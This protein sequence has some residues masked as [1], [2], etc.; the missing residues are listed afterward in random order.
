[1][2]TYSG[3][4]AWRISWTEE[5]G[6]LQSMGSQESD[7]TEQP[8]FHSHFQVFPSSASGKEPACQCRKCERCRF[9]TWVRKIP[10]DEGMATHSS[11]LA[12]RIPWT[13]EPGGL[14]S[15]RLQSVKHD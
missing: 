14:Q 4:L 6:G 15:V 10:P 7:M 13:E 2:A 5:P 12:W 8:T 3:I 11:I 1:M 9:N